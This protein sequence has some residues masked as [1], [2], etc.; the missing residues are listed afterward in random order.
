MIELEKTYL[1]KFLPEGLR[2][3]KSKEIIDVYLPKNSA[4]PK[5][6]LRKNGDKFELTKKEPIQDGDAGFLFS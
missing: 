1:L 4:H 3:F 6:R 2:D 5:L